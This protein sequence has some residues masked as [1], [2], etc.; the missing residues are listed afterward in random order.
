MR[1]KE[2]STRL[3]ENILAVV[4]YLLPLGKRIGNEWVIG[5]IEG[6]AGE[7]LKVCLD[8]SKLGLFCDFATGEKG[9]LLDLWCLNRKIKI[10]EAI[11]EVKQWLGV[12]SIE[13]AP[14]R[15][16]NFAKPQLGKTVIPITHVSQNCAVKHYLS[17]ERQLTMD[18]LIAFDIAV[19]GRDIVFPFVVDGE[20]LQLK[21]LSIDRDKGK[22]KIRVEKNCQ[23]CLFGWQALNLSAREIV[24]TEGEIDAM[25]LHQYG[26]NA[27]SLPFG[28]GE[29]GKHNWL[30][31]EYDR[32]SH[33]DRIYLCL[34]QDEVGKKTAL[35]LVERLGKH[36][37][38][39]VN[40]PHKDAN[41]CLQQDVSKEAIKQCFDKAISCDPDELKS[42]GYYFKEVVSEFYSTENQVAGYYTPWQKTHDKIFFRP[43]ELSV[44]TGINGHGKSQFL[45]HIILHVMN[46]G[47]K[48]CIASLEIKPKRL[49]MR[50]TRQATGLSLP[51]REYIQAV[52][53]WYEDKLWIFDLVGTAKVERILEVFLYARQCYGVDFFVIDSF[54]KCG[55]AED[56]YQTQKIFIEKL[57]DFKNEHNCQI[58]LIVHP[59]KSADESHLPNKL[60][61][62][63]TGAIS[64]LAD[65][66]FT[67]WRNKSKESD[68]NKIQS[69]GE[70]IA[71]S[72]TEKPDCLWMCDKHRNGEWEGRVGLYFDRKS[73][74]YLENY[75]SRPRQ[76]VDFSIHNH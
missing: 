7:S 73:Y 33:F 4:H 63:G 41:E 64:D 42:A 70:E 22:K 44:W 15:S 60:D 56:D 65:N 59:R 67:I 2:I 16:L 71:S 37:C 24:L 29:A 12:P 8:G 9:D 54:M 14:Q 48:V 32:L 46:Q 21:Y 52:H 35:S 75:Q 20:L 39:I 74:Q 57:C 28:G 62:K 23:P 13:I 27:L 26:Y 45:G 53:D 30:V 36:R 69:K 50:L 72:L 5:N 61:M 1:A 49:L 38:F 43:D 25:T 76:Y 31:Y 66:C 17:E 6:E 68:I 34:D 55:I 51:T 18:T 11:L 3:N 58:H 10:S 47:G 40:L 19:I